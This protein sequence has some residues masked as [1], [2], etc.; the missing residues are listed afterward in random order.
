[1]IDL[2]MAYPEV[3]V[4]VEVVHGQAAFAL[5][6]QSA[7]ADLLLIS[8]PAHGGFVHYLGATA[9]AV[10]RD[11]ACPIEVVPPIDER[12]HVEPLDGAEALVP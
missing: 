12:L 8:R 5:V 4:Q 6:Q 9:R 2:R 11:V 10:I 3:Q 1:M 7:E